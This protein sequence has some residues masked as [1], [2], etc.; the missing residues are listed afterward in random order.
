MLGS[1]L[2]K[3]KW[4]TVVLNT[5]LRRLFV[6]IFVRLSAGA[7]PHGLQ[8]LRIDQVKCGWIA[9][10]RFD[11]NDLL[12]VVSKKKPVFQKRRQNRA[13]TRVACLAQTFDDRFF[14]CKRSLAQFAERRE[15]SSVARRLRMD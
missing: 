4:A 10:S 14:I 2:D 6:P 12:V 5:R 9:F 1:G 7:G 13:D 11:D 8:R 15:E 3:P